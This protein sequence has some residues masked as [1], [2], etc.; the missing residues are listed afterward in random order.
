MC[1]NLLA[2]PHFYKVFKQKKTLNL[3]LVVC[4]PLF[5]FMP[6]HA[7][8]RAEALALHPVRNQSVRI[9]EKILGAP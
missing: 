8:L 1:V 9:T 4:T 3:P 5:G 6:P 2:M 7:S